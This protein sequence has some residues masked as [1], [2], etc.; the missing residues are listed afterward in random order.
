MFVHKNPQDKKFEVEV[1]NK[2]LKSERSASLSKA[3]KSYAYVKPNKYMEITR[4]NVNLQWTFGVYGISSSY[5]S[6]LNFASVIDFAIASH[7]KGIKAK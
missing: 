1:I 6:L 4:C 2:S 7:K 3:Y 5:N